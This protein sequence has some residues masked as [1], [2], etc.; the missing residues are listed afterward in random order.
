[1]S[2]RMLIRNLSKGCFL[3]FSDFFDS[4]KAVNDQCFNK[5]SILPPDYQKGRKNL[6][7]IKRPL[8]ITIFLLLITFAGYSQS[9]MQSAGATGSVM[10]ATLKGPLGKSGRFG[11]THIHLNYFPRIN[12]PLNSYTSISAGVPLGIGLG[13][14][15]NNF[16]NVK[17]TYLSY[18]IPLVIDYN[19]GFK[20]AE[21]DDETIGFYFGLGFGYMST[22]RD[23]L[24][25]T[26]FKANS[27]GILARIGVRLSLDENDRNSRGI[28]FGLYHKIGMGEEKFKTSGLNVMLDF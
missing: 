24:G 20:A 16:L 28:S 7:M 19:M 11:M 23:T 17:G 8:L 5:F 15:N 14:M 25:V 3:T 22:Q 1:M 26:S 10:R 9:F 4:Y 12:F 2:Y 6:C 18:D 27:A 21:V 13:I